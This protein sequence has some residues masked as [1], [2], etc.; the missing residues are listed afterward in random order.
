M[1]L[2]VI[3]LLLKRPAIMAVAHAVQTE[4]SSTSTPSLDQNLDNGNSWL[5]ICTHKSQ[6]HRQER[7]NQDERKHLQSNTHTAA[8]ENEDGEVMRGQNTFVIKIDESS[9]LASELE[10]GVV[11]QLQRQMTDTRQLQTGKK[12]PQ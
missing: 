8:Q 4:A 7:E 3:Y 2:A 1:S 10:K 9:D 11:C 5:L 6:K 12:P